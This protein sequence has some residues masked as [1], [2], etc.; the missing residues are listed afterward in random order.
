MGTTLECKIEGEKY[1]IQSD[2]ETKELQPLLINDKGYCGLG[3]FQNYSG[4]GR[5]GTGE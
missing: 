3:Q 5:G 2:L 4:G 1:R